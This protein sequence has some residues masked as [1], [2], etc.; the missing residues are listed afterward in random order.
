MN[1]KAGN[2]RGKSLFMNRNSEHGNFRMGLQ[3]SKIGDE[4]RFI[5]D[6]ESNNFDQCSKMHLNIITRMVSDVDNV[7]VIKNQVLTF[8][9]CENAMCQGLLGELNACHLFRYVE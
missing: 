7:L 9:T 6:Q 2:S 8:D 3:N 1:R 5:P 4:R